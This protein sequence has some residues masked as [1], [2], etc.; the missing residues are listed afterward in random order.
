MPRVCLHKHSQGAP[1]AHPYRQLA[2]ILNFIC[3][4][5]KACGAQADSSPPT[6]TDGGMVYSSEKCLNHTA[7]SSTSVTDAMW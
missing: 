2:Y 4:C 3:T 5:T 6:M 1:L 7:E